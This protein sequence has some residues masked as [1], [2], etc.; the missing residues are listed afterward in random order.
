MKNAIIYVFSGTGNT[1]KAC[2]IYKSEFEKNGVET[3]LYTVKKGFENLPD[4]NNFDYVGFAYPIHG[5]NA[6]YIML[7]LAKALPRAI[8]KEQNICEKTAK[9]KQKGS[10][11]YA[12]NG[13]K[14]CKN[15]QYFIVKTS[16]EPLKINNVSSIK[17][18]DIMKKKGYVLMSE[19]HYVM[20][21]NM[22]FRHTDE[23]AA[24]MKNTL[25]Q[26][27]P[28]EAREVICGVEHKLSKVPFGRFVA[29][30]VRIEQ[31][32]MKVNG[33]FFKVDGN[34]CI[35]CGACAKNCPVGNIKMD[36]NGKFSFG[37]DCVMCTRCS[38]NCPTNAFD[39]GML[40]GWKVN[41]RYSYKLPE[42]PEEDKHAWYCQKA[43]KRYFE[44][45]QRKI[46]TCEYGL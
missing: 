20:P 11:F 44:D 40:N 41:G 24:R 42:K 14:T 19:Y 27:A 26:L 10:D 36:G 12:K 30:V 33:R 25:E 31:P 6:P 32:A 28:V 21:Y 29:W 5:F 35:K 7:D 45:A 34:K 23:M 2:D 22:I 46:A 39:I 4:P 17:F 3:T 43:Y 18:N 37:G 9:N 16:G 15:K 1:K 8:E 13:K 38:F